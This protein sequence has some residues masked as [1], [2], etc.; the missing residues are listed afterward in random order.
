MAVTL[1]DYDYIWYTGGYGASDSL[2]PSGHHL[3][4]V[5][6]V[7]PSGKI[8]WSGASTL[9]TNSTGIMVSA[10]PSGFTTPNYTYLY[11]I[12]DNRDSQ[13]SVELSGVNTSTFITF[14]SRD[15]SSPYIGFSENVFFRAHNTLFGIIPIEPSGFADGQL[16]NLKLIDYVATTGFFPLLYI[17]GGTDV[18]AS[19]DL[20]IKVP[21]TGS[22]N[23]SMPLFLYQNPSGSENVPLFIQNEGKSASVKLHIE[24]LRPVDT[25]LYTADGYIP[26]TG[27]MNMFISRGLTSEPLPLYLKNTVESSNIN[28]YTSAALTG[29]GYPTFTIENILFDQPYIWETGTWATSAM[30]ADGHNSILTGVPSGEITWTNRV[31]GSTYHGFI[32][33]GRPSGQSNYYNSLFPRF[34]SN[35]NLTVQVSGIGTSTVVSYING[36]G[37]TI[38]GLGGSFQT[39]AYKDID[40]IT[41]PTPHPTGALGFIDRQLVNLKISEYNTYNGMTLH[42]NCTHDSG[43]QNIKLYTHGF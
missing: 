16:V 31:T 12:G 5:G 37:N 18:V 32:F 29:I 19:T 14:N 17:R 35:K 4:Q 24:G 20:H 34:S 11:D 15:N 42:I 3:I 6:N 2:Y 22:G 25:G 28:L 38:I 39:I 23:G 9:G 1:W 8:T 27:S 33:S 10:C 7:V 30:F 13:F 43:N 41:P 40:T 21:A 36:T 26:A